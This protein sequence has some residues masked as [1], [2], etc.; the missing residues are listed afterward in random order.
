M[1]GKDLQKQLEDEAHDAM[2]RH[3]ELLLSTLRMLR[4]ALHNRQ[5]EKRGK[6]A[7]SESD[8]AVCVE[9]S[10][11][12]VL[13]VIR[14]EAK[15]RRDALREFAKAGRSDLAAQEGSELKILERYLP[16]ELS[17]EEIEKLLQP[18]VA[19]ASVADFGRIMGAAMKA[20]SGRASGDRVSAIVRRMLEAGN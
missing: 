4:A 2:K 19:G 3:D 18:I 9:L 13:E 16:A 7:K 14:N 6:M 20:M 1:A 11:E 12:E 10:D 15:R 8:P 17:D 5:I